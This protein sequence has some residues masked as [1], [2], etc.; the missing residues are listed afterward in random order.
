MRTQVFALTWLAYASYY[1]C[2]KGFAVGKQRLADTFGLSMDAL[3]AID[4][5]YLAA[6]ALGQFASGLACDAIGPRRLIAA[7]MLVSAAATTAF[8]LGST[9]AVFAVAFAVNGLAQSTGW[10]GTVKAMTPWYA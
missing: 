9:S 4:T 6:Y 8:G 1:L 5:G 7:G 3:G 10:P 2:R